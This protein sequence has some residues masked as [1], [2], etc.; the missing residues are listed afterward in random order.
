M[1]RVSTGICWLQAL[2]LLTNLSEDTGPLVLCLCVFRTISP[3]LFS[4][5]KSLNSGS[6][7]VS[8]AW[9]IPVLATECCV[10]VGIRGAP[11]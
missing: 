2:L 11:G 1:L 9:K 10:F 8:L 3:E 7:W 5:G 4:I 6:A